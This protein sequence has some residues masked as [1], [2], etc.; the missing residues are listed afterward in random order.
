M[1]VPSTDFCG[2]VRFSLLFCLH[3]NFLF[4][5]L[6]CFEKGLV[7]GVGNNGASG[8]SCIL[9]FSMQ[10]VVPYLIL[11]K[12]RGRKRGDFVMGSCR[13]C[14]GVHTI[15]KERGGLGWVSIWGR[16]KVGGA[17]GEGRSEWFQALVGGGGGGGGGV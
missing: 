17:C 14:G 13:W 4:V 1:L 16:N 10:E 6:F 9:I 2:Q 8:W 12:E 11:L 15:G 5:F 3:Y 7:G